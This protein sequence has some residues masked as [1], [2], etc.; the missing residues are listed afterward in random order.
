MSAQPLHEAQAAPPEAESPGRREPSRTPL[1]LVRPAPRKRRRV[2]FVLFCVALVAVAVG[3]VLVINVS[4]S[5]TQYRLVSLKA[6]QQDLSQS[7]EALT[8]DLNNKRAPQ[9]LAKAAKA[10]NMVPGAQPGTVDLAKGKITQKAKPAAADDSGEAGEQLLLSAPLTPQEQAQAAAAKQEARR[11]AQQAATDKANGTAA[12]SGTT[13]AVGDA[14]GDTVTRTS[15]D[16]AV[17]AADG[18]PAAGKANDQKDKGGAPRFTP[19]ELNGGT[20]PGP[21]DD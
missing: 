4:V 18:K 21:Q 20:L 11:A 7:N 2:P 9:N 10:D 16:T 5:R 17:D 6:Q 12:A 13:Q 3:S 14:T 15:S 8:E 1:S 19:Q